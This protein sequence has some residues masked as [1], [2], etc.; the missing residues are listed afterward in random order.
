MS[1]LG[2]IGKKLHDRDKVN[3]AKKRK[4]NVFDPSEHVT[5]YNSEPW[6]YGVYD[7]KIDRVIHYIASDIKADG[8]SVVGIKINYDGNDYDIDELTKVYK[9]V[10]KKYYQIDLTE[11]EVVPY[12]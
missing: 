11:L 4:R 2:K 1:V 3:Q 9:M 12:A 10:F 6:L 8:Y 7:C 5:C